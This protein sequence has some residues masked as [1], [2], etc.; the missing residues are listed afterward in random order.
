MGAPQLLQF[1]TTALSAEI[2]SDLRTDVPAPC[3]LRWATDAD[4]RSVGSKSGACTR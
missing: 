3:A 1:A 4:Q 2:W